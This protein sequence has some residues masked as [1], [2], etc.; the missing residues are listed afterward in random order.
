MALLPFLQK[1]EK[2]VEDDSAAAG[3]K[4]EFARKLPVEELEGKSARKGG[5]FDFLQGM[6]PRQAGEAVPVKIEAEP[7]PAPVKLSDE[8]ADS[9]E[10]ED[11]K[12]N[13]FLR[14]FQSIGDK[15]EK[16]PRR[17]QVLEVNL[18][19]GEIVKYFDWQKAILTLLILVFASL[20]ALSLAYWG[21]SWWGASRQSSQSAAYLSDYFKVSREIKEL[22]PQVNDVLKFKA[23][24]DL[25]DFL[26][27]RHIYWN[28]FFT[29]LEENTLSNVYF[30][31]FSGD[32]GGSYN[33]SATADSL[34]AIDAQIKKFLANSYIKQA[35][36]SAGSVSGGE[37]KVVV[38]F[39]LS[40]SLNPEIFLTRP[41]R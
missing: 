25:A 32:I 11:K 14:F 7:S 9:A 26:L 17:S 23:R 20:T 21:I 40:F 41:S 13:F 37:G 27:A 39:S 22:E 3:K 31:G 6:A 15:I 19:R 35:S 12:E 33:L 34:D 16:K 5:N 24:L 4:I 8:E 28:N 30:S 38:S 36:V 2:P 29:F 18:V 10:P 1:K